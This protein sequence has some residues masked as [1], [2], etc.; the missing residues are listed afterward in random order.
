MAVRFV[1]L[2]VVLV[3]WGC[4]SEADDLDRFGPGVEV[5]IAA[6]FAEG[7]SDSDVAGVQDLLYVPHPRLGESH[8]DGVFSVDTD[9]GYGGIFVQLDPGTSEERKREIAGL[10][11]ADPRVERVELDHVVGSDG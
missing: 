2:L 5:D 4:Q 9:W 6:F 3:V 1:A 7:V 11:A 10:L 8:I